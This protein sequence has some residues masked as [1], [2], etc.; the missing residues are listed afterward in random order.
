MAT[1]HFANPKHTIKLAFPPSR[2]SQDIRKCQSGAMCAIAAH[3]SV[4]NEPAIV[5]LPTGSGKTGLLLA[6]P[7]LLGA[8]R[9][10]LITSG[11]I[12]RNQ[13]T[14]DAK[15]IRTLKKMKIADASWQPP[16]VEEVTSSIA[17]LA[18]WKKLENFDLVVGVPN[19]V[20]PSMAGVAQPP[21]NLFDLIMIDEA[22]HEP[23]RT[24][25][26]LARAFPQAKVIMVT[27]T[28]FRGDRIPL[29]GKIIYT[30]SIAQALNDGVL[31]D[32]QFQPA[33]LT[34]GD[35]DVI[36]AKHA[37]KTFKK[38]KKA[39]FNHNV[40]ARVSTIDRAKK[41]KKIYEEHTKLKMEEL[42]SKLTAAEIQGVISALKAGSIQGVV[43]VKMLNEGFDLPNLKI[44]VVHDQHKSL[45]PTVQFLGRFLRT[46]DKS[47]GTATLIAESGSLDEA[48][49]ELYRADDILAKASELIDRQEAESVLTSD[50]VA[51]LERSSTKLPKRLDH[52]IW[53]SLRPYCQVKIFS[54][55]GV[56]LSA[57]W[58]TKANVKVIYHHFDH[59]LNTAAIIAKTESKPTWITLTGFT[60]FEFELVLLH[61]DSN[62]K[63][64]YVCS[65]L[66]SEPFYKEVLAGLSAN[67][68]KSLPVSMI[69]R[70]L[71]NID[72]PHFFTIGL[73][74][75]FYGAADTYRTIAGPA[76]EYSIATTDSR[77]FHCSHLFGRG[78]EA[79]K[80]ITIGYSKASKVWT[81]G[82]LNI[83]EYVAWCGL[84]GS[85]LVD[86]TD[87][88]TQTAVDHLPRPEV[89]AAL[90]DHLLSVI[91]SEA[92]YKN[93]PTV[94]TPS[95]KEIDLVDTSLNAARLSNSEISLTVNYEDDK[96]VLNFKLNT[97]QFSSTDPQFKVRRGREWV[98]LSD[99]FNENLP[100]FFFW[101]F[102]QLQGNQLWKPDHGKFRP[103]QS[104]RGFNTSFYDWT[105]NNVNIGREVEVDPPSTEISIQ[106]FLRTELPKEFDV[107]FYNQG[108]REYADFIC[109]KDESDAVT[110]A[111]YHCKA[112]GGGA[113][114][115]LRQQDLQEVILQ[116]LNSIH[117]FRKLDLIIDHVAE[118]EGRSSGR[119]YKA[120]PRGFEKPSTRGLQ[121]FKRLLSQHQKQVRFKLVIAHPGISLEELES[122]ITATV[123]NDTDRRVLEAFASLEDTITRAGGNLMLVCSEK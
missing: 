104:R 119:T 8:R 32:I 123:L 93:P 2:N 76:V 64:L 81:S 87:V 66:N 70:V 48:G 33:D 31:S 45:L 38:D 60:T 68:A 51:D 50:V 57:D 120:V 96:E 34:V 113:N 103:F 23:A 65:T 78:T 112:S 98:S 106:D 111:L 20:S 6:A 9:V 115:A 13:I 54:T 4:D 107:V 71:R 59:A 69:R 10:L 92:T 35:S 11:V 44:A 110:L 3:F 67:S 77:N 41:V 43:S 37:E 25:D 58:W 86:T 95:A 49:F 12:L 118:R 47:V 105:A 108:S 82:R 97:V 7:Y 5:A 88:S 100:T 80:K 62:R 114:P 122:R 109:L 73:S 99:Y 27:A 15:N 21:P 72:D 46:G 28:P 24:W 40:V 18:D 52:L 14:D 30:Y 75:G 63:L 117:F 36:L 102:S 61:F 94:L 83:R 74:N 29:H 1:S 16:C 91:L 53:D 56:D 101:D 17:T 39:G 116:A 85:K 26:N 89:I 90:P 121:E 19:T 84:I 55:N 42:H 79:G 22:H